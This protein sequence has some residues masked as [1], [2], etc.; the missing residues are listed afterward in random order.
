MRMEYIYIYKL[1]FIVWIWNKLFPTRPKPTSVRS[2]HPARPRPPRAGWFLFPP[3]R[4][5]RPTSRG[6]FL[7][8]SSDQYLLPPLPS[9]ARRS[10]ARRRSFRAPRGRSVPVAVGP[11]SVPAAA[12]AVDC[13]PNSPIGQ[14][15]AQQEFPQLALHRRLVTLDPR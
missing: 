14:P 9:T 5:C 3:R 2:T 7:S 10:P 12:V 4:F 15:S 1:Y 6:G 11:R 8:Q 13:R